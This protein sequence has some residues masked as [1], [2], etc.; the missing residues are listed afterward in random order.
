MTLQISSVL[1]HDK[2]GKNSHVLATQP[3]WSGLEAV[4][5]SLGIGK[6]CPEFDFAILILELLVTKKNPPQNL[7]KIYIK[8]KS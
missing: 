4:I 5:S 2:V 7:T 8:K 3:L 1:P 6:N